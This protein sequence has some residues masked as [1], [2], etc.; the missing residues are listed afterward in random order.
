MELKI[1]QA[2]NIRFEC[3]SDSGRKLITL[4]QL[5]E[6][7]ELLQAKGGAICITKVLPPA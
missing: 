3:I 4:S 1:G 7:M 2:M 5:I 6:V